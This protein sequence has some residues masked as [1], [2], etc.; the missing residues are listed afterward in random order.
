MVKSLKGL[1]YY[2]KKRNWTR[3]SMPEFR[4]NLTQYLT[5]E[6]CAA[7]PVKNELLTF[8]PNHRNEHS[9]KKLRALLQENKVDVSSTLIRKLSKEIRQESGPDFF[10]FQESPSIHGQ[11]EGSSGYS[12]LTEDGCHPQ[13]VLDLSKWSKRF[14][15]LHVSTQEINPSGDQWLLSIDFL[16]SQTYHL[17]TKSMYSDEYRQIQ[18][19]KQRRL[20]T[21]QLFSNERTASEQAAWLDNT[22]I[23]Y[24]STN[25]YYN[26]SALYLYDLET[27]RHKLLFKGKPGMF[28]RFDT[29]LSGLFLTVYLSDYHSD[30]VYLIDTDTFRTRLIFPR[31]FSVSYPY[32]NHEKGRWIICKK[33]KHRDTIATTDL[34]TW[35]IHYQNDNPMEQ[36]LEIAYHQENLLFTLQTLQGLCLYGIH[37]GKTKLL[38]RSFDSYRLTTV[39]KDQFIV[40]RCKYTCPY[41]ILTVSPEMVLTSPPMK[42]RYRE[43]ELWVHPHLRVTVLYKKRGGPCLLKGYG[44]YNTYEHAS[45]S[46][47]YYPLLERGFVVAIAHLRGGGEYGYKGYDEGRMTKKKNTFQDFIDTAHF[48]VKKGWT[49]RDQLAIWGRSCGGLLVSSVLNQEPDLCKVALVGVPFITPLETMRSYKTPL[50]LESRSELGDVSQKKVRDYIHSYAPLEHI[51]KEGQYPHMLI[52]TNLNDTLVPYKEPLSYYHALQEVDVYRKGTSDLSFYLDSRFGHFQGSLLKDRCDH[53]AM[54]FG[55]VLHHL[56]IR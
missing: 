26:D 35:N 56:N 19:P 27:K 11:H 18:I 31:V 53:Y 4:A 33:E 49:T 25:R 39:R 38:E 2:F 7:L 55:Y 22:R 9:P 15:Y 16:G 48:L 1:N 8:Q 50:G 14:P 29:V 41:Q 45:E 13:K 44:A 46:P 12:I 23:L 5:P 54:L 30:E 34:K 32:I 42:P 43:E 37:C 20:Q 40:H 36:I 28:L 52:Y 6:E 3:K 24:V 17:F 10:I 21:H 47:F 51:K